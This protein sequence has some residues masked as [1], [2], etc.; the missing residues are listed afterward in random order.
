MRSIAYRGFSRTVPENTLAA[1]ACALAAGFS[2]VHTE[3]RLSADGELVLFRDRITPEGQPVA[4]LS[5]CELS[6]SAGYLVPTLL[7]ALDAFP[8]AFWSI[9]IKT[10]A[11]APFV[12][13]LLQNLTIDPAKIL[14]VSFRHEII[15]QAEELMAAKCGLMV[16]HRPAALNTLLY[17][18]MP[19]PRLRTLVWHYEALDV[20]LLKQA[21]V[22]GFH[23]WV[24]GAE[25]DY[26]HQL[27]QE[28]GVQ[29]IITDYPEF[30]GLEA[31]A[32]L[33]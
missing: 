1:F 32:G 13:E 33:Q 5:R 19:H 8:D 20:L 2:G 28:F 14:L 15:L 27:C 10:P 30:I 18:A 7:E 16:A 12:I 22:L 21:N 4:A 6:L 26:E 3:V 23:N 24:Y 31:S 25:T 17:A 29:G 9:E 11:A